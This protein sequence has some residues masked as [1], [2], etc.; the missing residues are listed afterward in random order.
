M[1]ES[2]YKLSLSLPT[3]KYKDSSFLFIFS[4]SSLIVYKKRKK[5]MQVIGHLVSKVKTSLSLPSYE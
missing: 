2:H 4:S 1:L 5:R 3:H